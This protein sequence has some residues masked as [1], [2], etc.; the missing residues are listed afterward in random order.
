MNKGNLVVETDSFARGCTEAR[1][2]KILQILGGTDDELK[3]VLVLKVRGRAKYSAHVCRQ[4][5][6]ATAPMLN[7]GNAN[8]TTRPSERLDELKAVKQFDLV[9]LETRELN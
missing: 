5:P 6:I 9:L 7:A 8:A 2:K 4:H 3:V 1:L